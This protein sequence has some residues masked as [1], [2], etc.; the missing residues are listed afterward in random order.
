MVVNVMVVKHCS[1]AFCFCFNSLERGIQD[2]GILY[3]G[4]QYTGHQNNFLRNTNVLVIGKD[5]N[6]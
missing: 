4:I 5:L 6:I 2:T 3:T 1:I